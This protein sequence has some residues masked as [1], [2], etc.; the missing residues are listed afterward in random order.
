MAGGAVHAVVILEKDSRADDGT[1][2]FLSASDSTDVIL[3]QKGIADQA[4]GQWKDLLQIVHRLQYSVPDALKMTSQMLR[5]L[6]RLYV[7]TTLRGRSVYARSGHEGTDAG[8]QWTE[9][10][11]GT[12]T[13]ALYVVVCYCTG[14]G[15]THA[16][17][18]ASV[19]SV[20]SELMAG[21]C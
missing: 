17:I 18:V 7:V 15:N 19:E 3:C 1:G 8:T 11:I 2:Q 9:G 13:N 12:M 14:D 16:S 21:G 20:V 10:L 6:G 5:V 4:A